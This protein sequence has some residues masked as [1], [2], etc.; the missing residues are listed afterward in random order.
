M[1]DDSSGIPWLLILPGVFFFLLNND[2]DKKDKNKTIEDHR[3][4]KAVSEVIDSTQTSTPLANERSLGQIKPIAKQELSQEDLLIKNN[5]MRY[6]KN[7]R[8]LAR[9]EVVASTNTEASDKDYYAVEE[10]YY[11]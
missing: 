5:L 10:D 3:K 4:T 11:D 2:D 1:S 7:K 6:Y 9:V 8:A